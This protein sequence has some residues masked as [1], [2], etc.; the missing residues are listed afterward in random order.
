MRTHKIALS[1]LL[2]CLSLGSIAVLQSGCAGTRYQ[3]STGTYL[4]DKGISARVK[5]AL[6]RDP[7]VSGFEV[8]VN[9]FRGDVQLSGYVDTP[10]QKERAAQIARQ[11]PGVQLVTNNL[12][13]KPPQAVGTTGSAV[14][15]SSGTVTQPDSTPPLEN[16]NYAPVRTPDQPLGSTMA[17][18]STGTAATQPWRPADRGSSAASGSSVAK[19]GTSGQDTGSAYNTI[20]TDTSTQPAGAIQNVQIMVDNGQA[21]LSG[22][23]ASDA[24]RQDLERRIREIPGVRSVNNQLNVENPR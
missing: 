16:Q 10:Q 9:T 19:P 6:F 14:S 2:I 20:G 4:D 7:L 5:T 23:V 15:S 22:T 8:N 12:E 17:A 13:V 3:R 21:T 11:I 1:G 24:Q 18:G